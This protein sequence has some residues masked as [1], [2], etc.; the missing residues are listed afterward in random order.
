MTYAEK[1][2]DPRWQKKRLKI[3]NRD[4]WTCRYCSDKKTTLHVHHLTYNGEPYKT[5]ESDLI[6]YCKFCHRL[7]EWYKGFAFPQAQ[8]FSYKKGKLYIVKLDEQEAID[9]VY[10]DPDGYVQEFF[11]F[12]NTSFFQAISDLQK[13]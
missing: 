5:K 12:K 13:A 6:T 7:H 1:L 11:H 10:V 4:K 2:Q 8:I 3:L 9:F